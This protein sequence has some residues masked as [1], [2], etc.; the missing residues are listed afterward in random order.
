MDHS[1][2]GRRALRAFEHASRPLAALALAAP[3]AAQASGEVSIYSYREPQPVEPLMTAFTEEIGIKTNVV[4]SRSGLDERRAAEGRNSS[5]GDLLSIVA[6]HAPNKE[7][8]TK[9]MEFLASPEAQDLSAEANDKYPVGSDVQPSAVVLS[10]GKL[11]PDRS[12]LSDI[13]DLRKTA[14]EL[15]D[16]LDFDA[17][18]SS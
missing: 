10:W 5:A 13:A 18:P 1:T 17:G 11:N 15:A 9:L 16:T 2:A 12:A 6:L 3:L 14:S 7:N 8:A 4:Y